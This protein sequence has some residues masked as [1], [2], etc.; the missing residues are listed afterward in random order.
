[1]EGLEF[2]VLAILDAPNGV[3][4]HVTVA[5]GFDVVDA[6]SDLVVASDLN[7]G[8]GVG[9]WIVLA[10]PF[11]LEGFGALDPGAS[12]FAFNHASAVRLSATD[13]TGVALVSIYVAFVEDLVV[14]ETVTVAQTFA[15]ADATGGL[16]LNFLATSAGAVEH[17]LS[18]FEGITN[19]DLFAVFH[20]TDLDQ[21]AAVVDGFLALVQSIILGHFV[22][23]G[24]AFSGVD[25]SLVG[26][27]QLGFGAS[28]VLL[29]RVEVVAIFERF[30]GLVLLTVLQASGGFEGQRVTAG[31]AGTTV[32]L[33]V[34]VTTDGDLGQVLGDARLGNHPST[35]A[36][37]DQASA[38]DLGSLG[39]ATR[40]SAGTSIGG[41][42]PGHGRCHKAHNDRTDLHDDHLN[43][44]EIAFENG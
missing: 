15:V 32:V 24:H 19:V 14:N 25:A 26:D 5:S 23:L 9:G 39:V 13:G 41:L 43:S 10:H 16:G 42:S 3:L 20:A 40:A 17:G 35:L 2:Q 21:F 37:V 11:V 4:L 30:S 18:N 7:L 22:F 12:Q 38:L 27:G 1:L 6:T 31:R 33:V 28:S 29:A 34:E 44:E 36:H 8:G